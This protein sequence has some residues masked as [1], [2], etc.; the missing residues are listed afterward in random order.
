M[1]KPRINSAVI[2]VLALSIFSCG[3]QSPEKIFSLA[4]LNTNLLSG[5]AGNGF[6]RQLETSSAGMSG[7]SSE[8]VMKSSEVLAGKIKAIEE[9]YEKVKSLPVNDDDKQMIESSLAV[10]KFVMPVLKNEY[11]KLAEMYDKGAPQ[12]EISTLTGEIQ[13]KY[14]GEYQKL[15]DKMIEYGKDYASKNNIKV[16]WN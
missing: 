4:V 8:P 10:Y 3:K 14:S 1:K 7:N 12:S 9:S 13:N 11:S 6:V 2:I 5:F 16:N 15:Y